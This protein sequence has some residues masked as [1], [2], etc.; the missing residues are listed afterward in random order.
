MNTLITPF[1]DKDKFLLSDFIDV[2]F[3]AEILGKT[4]EAFG[5]PGILFE[6][7]T[8]K[9]LAHSKWIDHEKDLTNS[10][11]DTSNMLARLEPSIDFKLFEFDNGLSQISIPIVIDENLVAGITTGMLFIDQPPQLSV[12]EDFAVKN[13]ITVESYINAIKKIPVL[14]KE[15]IDSACNCLSALS[16]V[17][18][19]NIS[20]NLAIYNRESK[21]KAQILE[22]KRINNELRKSEEKYRGL[23]EATN[24]GYAVID[25]EGTILEANANHYKMLGFNSFEEIVGHKSSEWIAEYDIEKSRQG[26]EKCLNAGI[27]TDVELDVIDKDGTIV[28]VE[29]N[30]STLPD[31]NMVIL[32][33]N[34]TAR[35]QAEAK[36]LEMEKR[37]LQVQK[38]ESLGLMAGGIAHDFNNLLTGVIGNADLVL[39]DENIG[40]DVKDGLAKI[41]LAGQQAANLCRQLLAYSGKGSFVKQKVDLRKMIKEMGAIFEVSISKK[42]SLKYFFDKNIPAIE[43]DPSQ[44]QQIIMNLIINASEAIG[45][46]AGTISIYVTCKDCDEE[47]LSQGFVGNEISPGKYLILEVTDSGCGISQEKLKIIF[48]PF[49]STK[50]TGRGLGLAAVKGIAQKNNGAVKIYS[51]PGQGTSF[52]I[53]LPAVA[54]DFDEIIEDDI[55]VKDWRGSGRALI[56]DDT[57]I[58]RLIG[59]NLFEFLGFDSVLAKDG[60]EAVDLFCE[61]ERSDKENI[62]V[63]LLDVSMPEKSG[64]EVFK[65]IRNI[66]K[67]IPIVLS[68]GY[69]EQEI[70]VKLGR[71]DRVAFVP[72]PY[73]LKILVNKL[74]PLFDH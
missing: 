57:E 9:I 68:S 42:I 25:K 72:K 17:I 52:R 35:K 56:V 41:I 3:V 16:A 36:R 31:S 33:K 30:A 67:D 59:K 47:Y 71:E 69:D 66:R 14:K 29:I 51:E 49:F 64:I 26:L 38:L 32:I 13:D 65:E 7:P 4:F 21:L 60:Q 62:S 74:K 12:F 54:G 43:I 19:K 70:V 18:K 39:Q 63:I 5:I 53:L 46:R 37:I 8:L 1:G 45:D 23:I 40:D 61:A 28:P 27:A 44:L 48:E 11:L 50:K 20:S 6:Y 58:A 73:D 10:L 15:K 2:E 55:A 22:T 24:I 34:I